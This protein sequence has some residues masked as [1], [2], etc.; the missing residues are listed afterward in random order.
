MELRLLETQWGTKLRERSPRGEGLRCSDNQIRILKVSVSSRSMLSKPRNAYGAKR[1]CP[2]L[3]RD[4]E[5]GDINGDNFEERSEYERRL[6]GDNIKKTFNFLKQHLRKHALDDIHEVVALKNLSTRLGKA[7]HQGL[8]ELFRL[9]NPRDAD[10]QA[11]GTFHAIPE[12]CDGL[13][14]ICN[15]SSDMTCTMKLWPI[16]RHL[17]TFEEDYTQVSC[18]I[19]FRGCRMTIEL[20]YQL[21]ET[22]RQARDLLHSSPDYHHRPRYDGTLVRHDDQR[23]LSFVRL[24]GI[25]QY[26]YHIGHEL[27]MV[28][29]HP[30]R[31]SKW[32]PRTAWKCCRVGE[33]IEKVETTTVDYLER[34]SR[35]RDRSEAGERGGGNF[36][37]DGERG[38]YGEENA[39]NT[40]KENAAVRGVGVGQI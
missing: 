39:E 3:A 7:F 27:D 23:T 20:R 21:R 37:A 22:W 26:T 6:P 13:Q 4:N 29:A 30:F 40:E 38:E 24:R 1:P 19:C 28:A 15:K 16:W 11:C 17:S 25:F 5:L 36:G 33:E 35:Q 12:R 32:K 31:P 10:E 2:S 9:T 8:A 34:G 18:K 14:Q